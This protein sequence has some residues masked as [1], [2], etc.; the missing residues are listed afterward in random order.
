[1]HLSIRTT[2]FYIQSARSECETS[3]FMRRFYEIVFD[4][5]HF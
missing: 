3:F 2:L 4:D 1:M 5:K